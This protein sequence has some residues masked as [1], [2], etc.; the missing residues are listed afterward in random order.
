MK[1]ATSPVRIGTN[2]TTN[3]RQVRLLL[4]GMNRV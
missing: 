1:N 2:R 3:L 4:G